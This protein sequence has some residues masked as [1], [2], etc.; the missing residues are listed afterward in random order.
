MGYILTFDV[1]TTSIKTCLFDEK[2]QVLARHHAE[3]HLITAANGIVEMNPQAYWQAVCAGT[4]AI[5]DSCPLAKNSISV[6]TITTQGE[7]LIPVEI[8]RAHV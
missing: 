1:G 8:G 4:R 3:Y 5:L 7:T 6:I 2:I